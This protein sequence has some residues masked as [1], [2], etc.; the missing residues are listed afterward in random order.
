MTLRRALLVAALVVLAG[1]NAPL[2]GDRAGDVSTPAV[3]GTITATEST[4]TAGA[5][6]PT[7]TTTAM[8]TETTTPTRTETPTE[9]A[10]PPP[11]DPDRY[12]IRVTGGDLPVDANRTYARV[13]AILDT[14]AR[15]P[16]EIAIDSPEESNIPSSTF[17]IPD[18]LRTL[19][20]V[21]EAPEDAGPSYAGLTTSG[22][23]IRLNSAILDDDA[24]T[25]IVL[26]HE[27][28]HTVQFRT[29]AFRSI[30]RAY[31][32]LGPGP[33]QAST[34]TIEGAATYLEEVYARQHLEDYPSPIRLELDA[35]A[36]TENPGRK[37]LV[38]PYAFGGRYLQQRLDS[39]ANLSAAYERPPRTTEA[40]IH[41]L[42]P[43]AEPPV[44]LSVTTNGSEWY[45]IGSDKRVGE[46]GLRIA[47]GTEVNDTLAAAGADG[48][49]N[50]RVIEFRGG[51]GEAFAWALRW[52]DDENATE[53]AEVFGRYLETRANRTDGLWRTG[54][55][56]A[57]RFVRTGDRTT[58]VLYGSPGFV[59]NASASGQSNVTVTAP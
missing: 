57:F 14:D 52:D 48:W 23:Q 44:P 41:G 28:V 36:R 46:L 50:D 7:S 43:G 51:E 17:R 19:G 15:A 13:A 22:S 35:Y 20:V 16:Y 31:D 33:R 32:V 56:T 5:T 55:G 9:T 6:D 42:E 30:G 1:C 40:V 29:D 3:D 26:A 12:E 38:A 27:Y 2:A 58:V 8:S 39:P 54:E 37:Y 24:R 45:A 53:F 34:A 4:T 47:L 10:T 59:R 18:A 25:E 49:G 11:D 21:Y